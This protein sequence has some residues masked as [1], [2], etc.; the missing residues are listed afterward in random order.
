MKKQN[1]FLDIKRFL[2]THGLIQLLWLFDDIKRPRLTAT[3]VAKIEGPH[4][5][6]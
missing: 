3:V 4:V 1:M 5:N 2:R 6:L